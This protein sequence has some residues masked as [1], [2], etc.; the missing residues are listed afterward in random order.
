MDME[1]SRPRRHSVGTGQRGAISRQHVDDALP[2]VGASSEPRRKAGSTIR[3]PEDRKLSAGGAATAGRPRAEP[4]VP[5]SSSSKRRRSASGR[6]GRKSSADFS[7][8][9]YQPMVIETTSSS[10]SPRPRRASAPVPPTSLLPFKP[11]MAGEKRQQREPGADGGPTLD[12]CLVLPSGVA[13]KID[14]LLSTSGAERECGVSIGNGDGAGGAD[15]DRGGGDDDMGNGSSNSL[16]KD[17]A[18]VACPLPGA[19]RD[20][21]DGGDRAI[22]SSFH[23]NTSGSQAVFGVEAGE[24]LEQEEQ[25]AAGCDKSATVETPDAPETTPGNSKG[26]PVGSRAQEG[27]PQCISDD[28]N[29]ASNSANG[30]TNCHETYDS[31]H[32]VDRS[33]PQRHERPGG[34][35]SSPKTGDVC[36]SSM[37]CDGEET[38]AI[39]AAAT[40]GND[41]IHSSNN[42][43][44]CEIHHRV[45]GDEPLTQSSSG[46]QPSSPETAAVC[47]SSMVVDEGEPAA[48]TVASGNDGTNDSTNSDESYDGRRSTQNDTAQRPELPGGLPSSPETE[49]CVSSTVGNEEESAA[50]V[51]ADTAP[52]AIDDALTVFVGSETRGTLVDIVAFSESPSVCDA[53]AGSSTIVDQGGQD[54]TVKNMDTNNACISG[55]APCARGEIGAETSGK[56]QAEAEGGGDPRA[57]S[58]AGEEPNLPGIVHKQERLGSLSETTRATAITPG[59]TSEDEAKHES[60]TE[61]AFHPVDAA[62]ADCETFAVGVG[63]EAEASPEEARQEE[64]PLPQLADIQGFNR[65][66]G[67]PGRAAVGIDSAGRSPV[68]A[69][70]GEVSTVLTTGETSAVGGVNAGAS[71]REG[72]AAVDVNERGSHVWERIIVAPSGTCGETSAREGAGGQGGDEAARNVRGSEV[73]VALVDGNDGALPNAR[74]ED[75]GESGQEDTSEARAGAGTGNC[76]TFAVEAREGFT[77]VRASDEQVLEAATSVVYEGARGVVEKAMAEE[78]AE[79][80]VGLESVIRAE[81]Q[82]LETEEKQGGGQNGEGDVAEHLTVDEE[83]LAAGTRIDDVKSAVSPDLPSDR[84]GDVEMGEEEESKEESKEEEEVDETE[85]SDEGTRGEEVEHGNSI[86]DNEALV[87]EAPAALSS[88]APDGMAAPNEMANN[89]YVEPAADVSDGFISSFTQ[90]RL[91]NNTATLDVAPAEPDGA[92]PP[93]DWDI[94]AKKQAE[95]VEVPLDW[96]ALARE[97]EAEWVLEGSGDESELSFTANSP[98]ANA[99]ASPAKAAEA[100]VQNSGDEPALATAEER[101]PSL[102]SVGLMDS[103]SAH[104]SSEPERQQEVEVEGEPE[105]RAGGDEGKPP[106]SAPPTATPPHPRR[107]V[108][109]GASGGSSGVAVT[110]PSVANLRQDT[111]EAND[112]SDCGSLR[113]LTDGPVSSIAG[114]PAAEATSS[115]PAL[116]GQPVVQDSEG[117]SPT[118]AII[119]AAQTSVSASPARSQQ[120]RRATSSTAPEEDAGACSPAK[121]NPPPSPSNAP[122]QPEAEAAAE[123]SGDVNG[124]PVCENSGHQ[125]AQAADPVVR[126]PPVGDGRDG[127]A[128]P[129]EAERTGS[130]DV[131][132]TCAQGSCGCVL[133]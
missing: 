73:E 116:A 125:D 83:H 70:T 31:H 81:N 37:V 109:D 24:C 58:G 85:R 5:S 40:S 131:G 34:Q 54:R 19:E 18:G 55:V 9:P 22:I 127:G 84:E 71:G 10:V 87:E 74:G 61:P 126:I 68:K 21:D 132:V 20:D 80:D 63:S 93:I 1:T 112:D 39:A 11:L 45:E 99:P 95:E 35:P 50:A 94:L 98:P 105:R 53:A 96:E 64:V 106:E 107:H 32:A 101:P 57:T 117:V 62:G 60:G 79:H 52:A 66:D 89:A 56:M 29:D 110:P 17:G 4:S 115:T 76:A 120:A 82:E 16:E 69:E 124:V 13:L 108:D 15:V 33:E 2:G 23:F 78:G 6:R 72:V 113:S 26:P 100:F 128:G 65:D 111:K 38:T 59:S 67:S 75:K 129:P 44:S 41:G 123:I 121:A 47:A 51:A 77:G 97:V 122:S 43:D 88:S 28:S 25:A 119:G 46:G 12:Q 91:D 42:V 130:G 133:M 14:G 114:L 86:V 103:G 90:E 8:S 104:G 49:V 7:F 36:G 102:A 27:V 3:P 118:H 92:T 48:A 30:S